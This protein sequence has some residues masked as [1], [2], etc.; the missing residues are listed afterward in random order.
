MKLCC[1]C[2]VIFSRSG[3]GGPLLADKKSPLAKSGDGGTN[4]GSETCMRVIF[5]IMKCF[6]AMFL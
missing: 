5:R 1:M 6:L 4:F 2:T 3:P